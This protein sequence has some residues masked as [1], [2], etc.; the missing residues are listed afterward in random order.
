MPQ[1]QVSNNDAAFLH[2]WLRGWTHFLASSEQ[3]LLDS[4]AGTI[5]MCALL[6]GNGGPVVSSEPDLSRAI[7][8]F[9]CNQRDV[10]YHSK[11]D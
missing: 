9:H 5:T 8:W 4:S 3:I 7:C 1:S 6:I 10:D 2:N 11:W